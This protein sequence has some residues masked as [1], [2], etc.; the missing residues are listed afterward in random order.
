MKEFGITGRTRSIAF[1]KI[2][3]LTPTGK[4][5]GQGRYVQVTN[6][7]HLFVV[8]KGVHNSIELLHDQK[9][10]CGEGTGRDAQFDKAFF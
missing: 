2:G 8:H 4:I 1:K 6:G 10:T 5:W 7:K 9:C 3:E